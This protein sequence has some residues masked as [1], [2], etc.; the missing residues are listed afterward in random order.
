MARQTFDA[1]FAKVEAAIT[2]K[3]GLDIR[4]LPDCPYME[5]YEQG[6]TP[7]AAASRAVKNAME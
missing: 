5:W 4:D 6:L 3:T 2:R 7:G 1:W